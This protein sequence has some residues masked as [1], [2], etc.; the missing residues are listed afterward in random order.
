M[1]QFQVIRFLFGMLIITTSAYSQ[2]KQ[3]NWS[4]QQC[5]KLK[6]ITAVRPS[7]DGSRVLYTVREAVMTADRSEYINQVFLCNSDGSNTIQ[8]TRGEK[9]SSNPKWS[10]DGKWVAYTSNRDGKNN[11]YVLPINGG[12]SEK[13]TDSK[14]GVNDFAWSPDDKSFALTMADSE[15]DIDEKNKKGKEDWYF[16]DDSVKQNRLYVVSL[17]EK[18]SSGK[19]IQKSLTKE[20]YNVIDFNWSPDGKQIAFTHG[21]TPLVNDQVYSDISTVD[22]ATGNTKK[23]V[24][25]PAGESGPSY[26]PDGKLIAYYCTEDKVDWAGAEHVQIYSIAD[27]KTWRLAATPNEDGGIIGWTADSK[28]ILWG[29]PHTTLYSVYALS[30]DGKK[31]SEWTKSGNDLMGIPYLNEGGSYLGFILQNSQKLPQA[32]VSSL[33]SYSPVKVSNINADKS[34]AA[35]PKTEVIKWKGA[36]GKE[37]EGLLT[38][39]IDYKPG[40]KVPLILNVHGGPAGVFSQAC[41]AANGGVYPI[42]T[43]SELGY[44]ILRPNPRGSTGYGTPFRTANHMD[45]GGADYKDLMLGVDEVIKM[46]IAEENNLGVMGWS[47]GGF[48]SSWI[49]GHTDRFKAASIGA[50]V[51]DL[52]HQNLTDDIAGFLPSYFDNDPWADWASYDAHSPLRFVQNVKTPVMLQHGEADMRVPFTNGLMF[53]HAL[54]RRGIPVRLLALPRQPHGP[55]EPKM[56]MR[57]MQANVEWFDKY[58]SPKKGF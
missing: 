19:R 11:L 55:T 21:R 57:V 18:D 44:A 35:L 40:Q 24:S 1:R 49:V 13:I 29:E 3:T 16:M 15:G 10:H 31:I 8:L 32:Y 42:A 45:W 50:P 22:V 51:V 56:L 25:S 33:A 41:V 28:T 52:A 38:Y 12:E 48:M 39:P 2:N 46:G 4:P 36:D 14:T 54:K 20:N 9:N 37:I 6:N 30:V 26:S 5:M 47:Y 43:F 53:Y 7:P 23:L 58:M 27:G 17:N 34:S